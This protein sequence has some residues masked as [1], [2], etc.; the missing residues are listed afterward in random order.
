MILKRLRKSVLR[1][2]K[3]PTRSLAAM[4]HKN[5]DPGAMQI[6][7]FGFWIKNS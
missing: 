1:K 2:Y 6:L 4:A 7:D 5:L 3:R